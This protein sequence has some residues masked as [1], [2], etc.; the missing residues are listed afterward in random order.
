MRARVEP[1]CFGAPQVTAIRGY[2]VRGARSSMM[3]ARVEPTCFG[4]R[5]V[6]CIR[7]CVV[8]G[9]RRA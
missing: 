3:R 9:A 8:R 1:T 6:T 4:A 5:Q 7:V 2:V